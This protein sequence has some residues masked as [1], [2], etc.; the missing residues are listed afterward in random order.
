MKMPAA[1]C[2]CYGLLSPYRVWASIQEGHVLHRLRPIL[3]VH[4]N[5]MPAMQ[6]D[7]LV[8]GVADAAT[9][10]NAGISPHGSPAPALGL[11]VVGEHPLVGCLG[12]AGGVPRANIDR[13]TTG[14]VAKVSPMRL[15]AVAPGERLVS[16]DQL[17]V[18]DE[19]EFRQEEPFALANVGSV[20]ASA[21]SL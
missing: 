18:H 3:R 19:A 14:A 7:G 6:H 8:V 1:A 2:N 5:S 21:A 13:L 12:H 17:P 10:E 9:N 15:A 16:E 4:Q 20:L 11:R